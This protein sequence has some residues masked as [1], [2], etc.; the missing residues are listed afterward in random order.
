MADVLVVEDEPQLRAATK[1]IVEFLGVK[2]D[3]A[4]DGREALDRIRASGM[5]DLVIT[6]WLM[7]NMGGLDLMIEL[8]KFG[9]ECPP[10][11]V[12]SG[13]DK[14]SG[15]LKSAIELGARKIITKPP[16]IQEFLKIVQEILES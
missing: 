10:I 8:K 1:E 6:D 12:V 15:T 16:N 13:G 9:E 3:V 2:V 11:I 7:P 5:P 14:R 4:K